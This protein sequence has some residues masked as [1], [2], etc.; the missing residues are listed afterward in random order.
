MKISRFYTKK[1]FQVP[2]LLLVVIILIMYDL[3]Q[4]RHT[5]SELMALFEEA[6]LAELAEIN[7]YDSLGRNIRYVEVGHDSLPLVVFIHGAPSSSSFWADFLRDPELLSR[8]KL[9]AVDR[10]GYGFSG[11]GN[12][13]TSVEK[14]A[15]LLAPIL[16]QKRKEHETIV[17]HGSSYGGTVTAR[18]AM[19]YPE[20]MDGVV[21]QSSSL[22]PGEEKTFW[23]TY[24]TSHWAFKWIVPASLQV[25]NSEKLS[26]K[27]EL[28]LMEPFWDR[29]KA[30]TTIL[31]GDKDEIVYP[32]NAEFA[33]EKLV[34]AKLV[35]FIM[36]E[37]SGHDL[38][39]TQRQLL[40]QSLLRTIRLARE[41]AGQ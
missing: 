37:G 3:I 26:H 14:Q 19:D 33:R 25:A 17:I 31:H 7:H 18:L 21:F 9:L 1:W 2:A 12:P 4:L 38:L 29:I 23:I 41:K 20:L 22:A 6:G 28:E 11:L 24:P 32:S 10:P 13:L 8:A 36:V 16:R 5:D 15:A 35:N 27:K 30:V 34:N 39:W 40:K